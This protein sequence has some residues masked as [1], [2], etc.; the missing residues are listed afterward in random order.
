MLAL[1]LFLRLVQLRPDIPFSTIQS[2]LPAEITDLD[3]L[4]IPVHLYF[5]GE[6]RDIEDRI[7]KLAKQVAARATMVR[8]ATMMEMI[9]QRKSS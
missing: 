5:S 3:S 8:L 6:I 1:F 2:V 9:G 4:A 7:K